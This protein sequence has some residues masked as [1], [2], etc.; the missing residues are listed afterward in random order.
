[1]EDLDFTRPSRS[2]LYDPAIARTCFEA[3][4]KPESIAQ[5]A[6]IFT[7]NQTTDKMYFLL[8]GEVGLS[9]SKKLIDI[10][11][12]GEIFGEMAAITGQPRSASAVA[13]IASRVIA[14]DGKQFTQ[15][16]QKAPEFVLML[17]SIMINRL[18]L[19]D[20]MLGMTRSLPDW[21]G[22]AES[23]IFDK[24]MIEE[25]ASALHGRPPQRY[26]AGRMIMKEGDT[27]VFMYLVLQ[28]R[29]AISIQSHVVEKV[30]AGGLFGEM[31]L[32]DQSKRAATAT[33]ETDCV[34][35]SANR[36]DFVALVKTKPAFAVSLLK[37]IA[38]RLRFMT[39]HRS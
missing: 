37:A 6:P 11:K 24:K 17:M 21:S 27:G 20:A 10:V 9:R 14:L 2:E 15:A 25:L 7:E 34:L 3:L 33:A 30:G 18:R 39:S 35:A 19:T 31:A 38:E 1:M 26:P 13:R 29:V 23:K 32:L 8:E 16:I 22:K 12:A 4:G 5:G 28:G 36:D